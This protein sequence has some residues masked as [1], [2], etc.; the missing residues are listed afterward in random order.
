MSRLI[1]IYKADSGILANLPGAVAKAFGG[2]SVCSLCNITHGSVTQKRS[3][4]DF[5][6]TLPEKPE[7]YHANEI[8]DQVKRFLDTHNIVLPVVLQQTDD[9]L[10]LLVSPQELESCS[11]EPSCLIEKLE[12][13]HVCHN[14]VCPTS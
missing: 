13:K 10:S 8:P 14:G 2:K 1:F 5:L 6:K 3:W 7:V 4:T 9:E 11:G 12:K